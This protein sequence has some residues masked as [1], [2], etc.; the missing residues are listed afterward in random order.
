MPPDTTDPRAPAPPVLRD[1]DA[2][3]SPWRLVLAVVIAAGGAGYLGAYLAQRHLRS[4]LALRP[5]VILFDLA[6]AV[7]GGEPAGLDV[8][9]ERARSR[10]HRLAAGGFLVLDA[11]AV[12]AAPPELFLAA[13]GDA[14]E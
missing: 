5:P 8:R 12:I 4:E 13:E 3:G 9:L 7:K 1:A 14:A 10:A 6:E 11:Q 2:R